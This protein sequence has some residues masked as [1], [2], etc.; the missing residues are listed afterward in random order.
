MNKSFYVLIAAL[1]ICVCVVEFSRPSHFNWNATFSRADKN[2]FGCAV[3]DSVLSQSIPY[4]YSVTKKTLSQMER[5]GYCDTPRTIMILTDYLQLTSKELGSLDLLLKAGNNIFISTS[6]LN[7][8]EESWTD[9]VIGPDMI[10]VSGSYQF[11]I[12]DMQR[13]ISDQEIVIDTMYWTKQS[14]Y[15]ARFFC[16]YKSLTGDHIR[17]DPTLECKTL[18]RC[19]RTVWEENY[20]E[21]G[22]KDHE[23]PGEYRDELTPQ[24]VQI[25]YGKGNL[26]VSSNPLIMTNYGMLDKQLNNV[27]FRMLSQFGKLPIERTEAYREI[28][29]SSSRSPLSF[30]LSHEPLRWMT[31]M[32]MFGLILFCIFFARRR[33]RAIPIVKDPENNTLEFTKQI[34]DLYY[35]QHLNLDL[36][37]KRYKL[38]EE[39]L[40]MRAMIDNED[41]YQQKAELL[42]E[43]VGL[44]KQSIINLLSLLD[45]VMGQKQDISDKQLRNLI[46]RMDEISN[47]L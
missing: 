47:K 25:K 38:F 15:K 45:T 27:I 26:F 36:L 13:S 34:G 28:N 39:Q 43:R 2:P 40:R 4:G 44:D 17:I 14:P 32:T 19:T 1:L 35:Q 24:F 42:H 22:D 20:D 16:L 21:N 10:G 9:S 46:D 6:Y 29:F 23:N 18:M 37:M 41:S 3:F 5:E 31:Y 8:E 33:Q 12:R 30:F 11:S 7:S